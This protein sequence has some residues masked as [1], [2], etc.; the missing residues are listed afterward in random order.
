VT[1][2][3]TFLTQL[4]E[5]LGDDDRQL[6]EQPSA[7]AYYDYSGQSH[8]DAWARFDARFGRLR[9]ERAKS[10]ER[11]KSA[12]ASWLQEQTDLCAEFKRISQALT[13]LGEYRLPESRAEAA[14]EDAFLLDALARPDE[15]LPLLAF[16]DWLADRADARAGVVRLVARR[17]AIAARLAPEW[18]EHL[19]VAWPHLDGRINTLGNARFSDGAR[20]VFILANVETQR[21]NHEYLGT[22]HV[23][24][25]M[26][27]AEAPPAALA[28]C[29]I[30]L[31]AAR[32][33]TLQIAPMGPDMVTS[34][35]LPQTRRGRMTTYLAI[36]EATALNSPV[37]PDHLLLGLCCA[38]PCA[39]TGVMR[40][41]GVTP[42]D[43][44]RRVVEQMGHNPL[45]WLH[46]RPEVW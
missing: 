39:A 13:D 16:A 32:V 1:G 3:E 27:R 40:L 24:L 25:G 33:G 37:T 10:Y 11:L 21:L 6:L 42:S 44:C 22:H 2:E 26:L 12:F 4:L 19:D 14:M 38:G 34:G 45:R 9:Q 30:T 17:R 35:R 8:P 23:L 29:G 5:S 31:A 46:E 28:D 7:A 20:Q 15:E 36:L 41:L 18:A 43:L